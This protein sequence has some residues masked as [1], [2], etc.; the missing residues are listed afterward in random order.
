METRRQ[1]LQHQREQV[2]EAEKTRS[3]NVGAR[4]PF[5]G[6]FGLPVAASVLVKRAADQ[7]RLTLPEPE[8]LPCVD[9][10]GRRIFSLL[11]RSALLLLQAFLDTSRNN[12][13]TIYY[14]VVMNTPAKLQN[15]NTVLYSVH[16]FHKF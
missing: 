3:E 8:W 16:Y 9:P 10:F 2:I 14:T 1:R 4:I 11:P 13:Y 7:F 12:T 5:A 6:R 15:L